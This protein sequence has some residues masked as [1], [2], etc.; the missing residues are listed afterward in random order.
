MPIGPDARKRGIGNKGMDNE[1]TA[2]PVDKNHSLRNT[3]RRHS[4]GKIFIA[5][6]L[7]LLFQHNN[8]GLA[9]I[10]RFSIP[11]LPLS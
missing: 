8:T 11:R 6:L 3:P 9:G 2:V 1:K 10:A 7:I 5:A 4:S